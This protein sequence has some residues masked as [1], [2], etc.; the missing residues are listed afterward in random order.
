MEIKKK[1]GELV[2]K[3]LV[4][5]MVIIKMKASN[6]RQQLVAGLQLILDPCLA[7]CLQH[8]TPKTT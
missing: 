3:L 5:C 4:A 2:N 8:G 7:A 6:F 1:K